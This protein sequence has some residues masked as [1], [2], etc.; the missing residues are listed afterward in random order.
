MDKNKFR[1]LFNSLYQGL[2]RFASGYLNDVTAE[3]IVQESFLSLW[4]KRKFILNESAVKSFLYMT[5]RNKCINVLKNKQVQLKK[6]QY[7]IQE[8]SS[9]D[10]FTNH[11]IE[12]ELFN[13]LIEEINKLPGQ[14]KKVT[15][16]ALNGLK[17]PE[18]AKELD[19][20]VNTVKTQKKIAF[21]KLRTSLNK[22]LNGIL[23]AL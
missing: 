1:L 22:A 3:D 15:M 8:L 19:V 4:E 18:I 6:N 14:C 11:I 12:E 7:L 5:V 10:V 2:C 16:L 21:A 9:D 20:S 17:N 13:K 23:L